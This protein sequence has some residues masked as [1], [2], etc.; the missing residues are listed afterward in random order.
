MRRLLF[1]LLMAVVIIGGVSRSD[2]AEAGQNRHILREAQV[3][4]K[5]VNDGAADD[6]DARI[7]VRRSRAR[8]IR[9]QRVLDRLEMN[10]STTI[11]LGSFKFRRWAK[12]KVKL[13]VGDERRRVTVTE[14]LTE[15]G[16]HIITLRIGE[17]TTGGGDG[18]GDDIVF[19]P[20]YSILNTIDSPMVEAEVEGVIGVFNFDQPVPK[21]SYG[22]IAGASLPS[23]PRSLTVLFQNGGTMTFGPN[24]GQIVNNGFSRVLEVDPERVIGVAGKMAAP[25]SISELPTGSFVESRLQP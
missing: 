19:P 2:F 14:R 6:V 22:V 25:V 7:R 1:A 15:G 9:Y 24:E 13:R 5:V 23:G 17:T 16:D 12:V 3:V 10:E 21:G 20:G 18:G 8:S 11:D 4:V